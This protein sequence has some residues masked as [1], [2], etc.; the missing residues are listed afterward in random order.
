MACGARS[1]LKPTNLDVEGI[2]AFRVGM[3]CGARSGLKQRSF[4]SK[5]AISRCWNGLWG[6]FG[7]ETSHSGSESTNP[8]CWNGLWGPFGIETGMLRRNLLLRELLEWLVGPVR[9]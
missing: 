4:S 3:A 2:N 6:P 7:I 1:G 9:D 5:V 8:T